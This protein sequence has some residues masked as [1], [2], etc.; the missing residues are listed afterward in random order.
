MI[1]PAAEARRQK[2][3]AKQRAEIA[4]RN[5]Q[6]L[7]AAK[8]QN[9]TWKFSVHGQSAEWKK[10]ALQMI[11]ELAKREGSTF[12]LLQVCVM[13]PERGRTF[14]KIAGTNCIIAHG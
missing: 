11:E 7:S 8:N 6:E 5:A 1:T 9:G 12:K 10:T 13:L 2:G 14:T 4:E 3:I